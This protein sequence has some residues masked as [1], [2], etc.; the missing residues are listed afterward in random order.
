L[1]I[2]ILIL[3]LSP[4]VLL[5]STLQVY[6][7]DVGQ[8]DS[9]VITASSGEVVMI[10]SGPDESLIF[11]KL[12]TLNISH[13]DLLIA[14]HPHTDHIT[15]MDTIID[16]YQSRGFVDIGI[17]HTTKA[18]ECLIH[19]IQN[20]NLN[21]Y[22][23]TERKISLGLLIFHILP[24]ANPYLEI[25]E[26]NN[27][28]AVIR[29]DY[30]KVSFLFP[31]D[32]ESE[33][34]SQ[35]LEESRN[36]LNVDILKV[37]HHGSFDASSIGFIQ[38]VSPSVAII[39][40]GKDNPYGYPHHE[41]L[42]TLNENRIKTY[43]TDRQGTILVQTDGNSYQVIPEVDSI[44]LEDQD[45][46]SSPQMFGLVSIPTTNNGHQYAASKKSKVFHKISCPHVATIKEDNLIFFTTLE[47]ALATGRRGCKTCDPEKSATGEDAS[48]LPEE[49]KQNPALKL[50]IMSNPAMEDSYLY[51]ASKKSKIFHKISCENV[52]T[53]KEENLI[54]FQSL[55]EAQKSGRRGCK[56]FKPKE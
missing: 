21:Y 34:E 42:Q 54:F 47:E 2:L 53:I 27:N 20:N 11:Q 6:F 45:I 13:I 26:L 1:L 39:S 52:S 50:E 7:L 3:F 36:Q 4:S 31:G 15:G 10:D 56:Q 33:R 24:P 46:Q 22:Q 48:S 29:L 17:P 37:P 14:S 41:T 30:G 32:I 9:I 23:A 25:S 28:S 16:T 19:A 35:L 18:Y 5:A 55:K 38:A 49:V 40:C 8:G 43:R 44:Q 12:R 51:A